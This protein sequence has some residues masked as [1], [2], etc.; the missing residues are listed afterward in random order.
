[1]YVRP[2]PAFLSQHAKPRKQD[3]EGALAAAAPSGESFPNPG[4]PS[5]EGVA[6]EGEEGADRIILS[7]E[8]L[9]GAE[10]G[11]TPV[12]SAAVAP[13]AQA[14]NPVVGALDSVRQAVE[15]KPEMAAVVIAGAAG[16]TFVVSR[17][18]GG[19]TGR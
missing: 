19:G 14:K 9:D 4:I 11:V 6:A 15:S 8:G 3:S 5:E 1:M 7:E 18:A 16:A 12:M 13:R 2:P 10:G 17:G